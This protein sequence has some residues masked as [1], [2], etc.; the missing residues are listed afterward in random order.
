VADSF[1]WSNP[2]ALFRFI[3]FCLELTGDP[4]AHRRWIPSGDSKWQQD[5][6]RRTPRTE[7]RAKGTGPRQ[8]WWLAAPGETLKFAQS[9]NGFAQPRNRGRERRRWEQDET[10][11][12]IAENAKEEGLGRI[13]KRRTVKMDRSEWEE[14]NL[15]A[16]SL[17]RFQRLTRSRC[18]CVPRDDRNFG[19]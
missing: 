4:V 2:A 13:H 16:T 9:R 15:E 11:T 17:G 18:R 3:E 6:P 14:E 5:L 10:H 12:E 7:E 1:R 19:G 8:V